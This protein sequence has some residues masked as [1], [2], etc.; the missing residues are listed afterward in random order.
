PVFVPFGA[1]RELGSEASRNGGEA[2]VVA[3]V[4]RAQSEL[5]AK[6]S[7]EM[8][9][10][11]KPRI[12]GDLENAP[13]VIQGIAQL[14]VCAIQPPRLDVFGDAAQRFEHPVKLGSRDSK[15]A[16]EPVGREFARSQVLLDM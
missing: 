13:M 5:A 12:Q 15:A 10:A 3:Q 9:H 2:D 8:S 14:R 6:R 16:A 11:G 7:A 4:A 1:A